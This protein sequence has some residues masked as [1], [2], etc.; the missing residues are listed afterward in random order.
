MFLNS[1]CAI[2]CISYLQSNDNQEILGDTL[3]YSRI[4]FN[5]KIWSSSVADFATY[6][7]KL[8]KLMRGLGFRRTNAVELWLDNIGQ[9]EL[10][11]QG[12][13]QEYFN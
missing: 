5:I 11:Y 3:G 1:D 2:P 12:L 6:S 4:T 7:V 13:A 10:T 9:Y 8:D